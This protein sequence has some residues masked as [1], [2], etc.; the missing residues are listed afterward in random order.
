MQTYIKIYLFLIVK[1]PT[2][3]FLLSIA[4]AIK[5]IILLGATLTIGHKN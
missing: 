3:V 4:W 1:Y 5:E 2:H